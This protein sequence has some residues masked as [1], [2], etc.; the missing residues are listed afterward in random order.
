MIFDVGAGGRVAG[1]EVDEGDVVFGVGL[2]LG[3]KLKLELGV[4]AAG[5]ELFAVIS[6]L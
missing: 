3:L 5:N 6:R 4:V 2:E 1:T